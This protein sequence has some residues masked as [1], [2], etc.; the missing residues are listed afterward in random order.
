V[1]AAAICAASFWLSRAFEGAS[2][3]T[4]TSPRRRGMVGAALLV[5][6]V[7]AVAALAWGRSGAVPP[8]Q[9]AATLGQ[10]AIGLL[11]AWRVGLLAPVRLP[12][13]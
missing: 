8:A 2:Q 9:L 1:V 13:R 7:T 3:A 12:S 6:V 10:L 4:A 11:F 5:I